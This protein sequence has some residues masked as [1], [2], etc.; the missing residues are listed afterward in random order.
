MERIEQRLGVTVQT[1]WGMTELSPSGTVA[2]PRCA[3]RSAHLSGRPA[4][5]VDLLLTDA[6]GRPLPEQ[7]GVEGHLRVRG[8]SVIERYFGEEQT[9]HRRR[10]LVPHRRSGAH[11]RRR[12]SHHHRPR[13]GPDQ[14]GRRVDQPGRDRGGGQCAFPRS[15]SPRSSAGR[16]PSGAS[17]RSCWS[18][19]ARRRRHQRRGVARAAARQGGAVVD[20]RRGH[21]RRRACTC[22]QR[23]RSTRFA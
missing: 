4:V 17:A 23:V 7:R 11:R 21:P 5:G 19:T 14:V 20:P 8:A 3:A 22:R 16:T 10:R 15:R 2:P 6:E 18:Q 9:R 12:Q 13:Q 1:S